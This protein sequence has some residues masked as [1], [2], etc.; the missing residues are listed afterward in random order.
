MRFKTVETI[1]LSGPIVTLVL[2][3]IAAFLGGPI[4]R[5]FRLSADR[6]EALFTAWK[7]LTVFLFGVGLGAAL[8]TPTKNM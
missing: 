1:A 5:L 4:V 2:F 7:F 6:W 3:F 8:V